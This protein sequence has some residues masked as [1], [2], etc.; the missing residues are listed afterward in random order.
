MINRI[1]ILFFSVSIAQ[2]QEK[3]AFFAL[4]YKRLYL[5]YFNAANISNEW[6]NFK[7]DLS[8]D[9]AIPL[10]MVVRREVI[11]LFPSKQELTTSIE[12]ID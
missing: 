1:F 2:A 11:K 3:Q 12:I 5:Q 7:F 10:G 9:I 8:Q 4:Q 6:D